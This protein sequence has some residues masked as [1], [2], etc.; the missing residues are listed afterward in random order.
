MKLLYLLPIMGQVLASPYSKSLTDGPTI[1]ITTTT[2]LTVTVPGVAIPT[3]NATFPENG[4]AISTTDDLAPI[5]LITLPSDAPT[6]TEENDLE[7]TLIEVP[8]TTGT[9]GGDDAPAPTPNNI[10]PMTLLD[11]D[12]VSVI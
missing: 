5:T 11:L 12:T 2:T 9:D 6:T 1:T 3:F 4:T 8:A 10:A 7:P